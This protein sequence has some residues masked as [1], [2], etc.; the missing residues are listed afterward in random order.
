MAWEYFQAAPPD[1]RIDPLRGGEWL[2]LDGLQPARPR[3]QTRLPPARGAARIVAHGGGPGETVNL[4]CDTLAIDG[5]R[6]TFSL[7]WRGHRE[8][9]EGQAAR[10]VLAALEL[11]GVAID[12][13]RILATANLASVP[14]PTSPQVDEITAPGPAPLTVAA[15]AAALPFGAPAP[16]PPTSPNSAATPWSPEP[17]RPAPVAAPGEPTLATQPSP[18]R[19]HKS[20]TIALPDEEQALLASLPAVPFTLPAEAPAAPPVQRLRTEPPPPLVAPPPPPPNPWARQSAPPPEPEPPLP[21]PAPPFERPA[22]AAVK[23]SFYS[24]FKK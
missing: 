19:R 5:D 17:V 14:A 4:V 22:A 9:T 12:W 3:L 20:R 21:P 18:I 24:G 15:N 1:Q 23:D 11:P 13:A 7:S 2:V 10:T 6:Q 8:V 16:R